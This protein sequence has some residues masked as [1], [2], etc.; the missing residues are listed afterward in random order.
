MSFLSNALGLNTS[1]QHFNPGNIPLQN[2]VSPEQIQ[3]AQQQS[4][5]AL[6]GFQ[7]L[8]Q[9]GINTQVYAQQQQ[10]ANQLMQ[11]AQG[12]GPNPAQAQLNQATGQNVANQAALM[13]SQRGASANPNLVAKQAAQQ[14]SQ[15]QQQA[16]GQSATMGAQQQLAAQQA[17]MGQQSQMAGQNMGIQNAYTQAAQAQL[18]QM[19]GGMQ[20][21]NQNQLQL[22]GIK[23]GMAQSQNQQQGALAGGLLNAAGTVG[24]AM[25]SE[26]G[27]VP[28]QPE[29]PHNDPQNDKVKAML[30]PGELVIPLDAMKSKEAAIEFVNKHFSKK[31]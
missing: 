15:I 5:Q 6:G 22:G 18:Q 29:V 1:Q 13:G 23:A 2:T 16:A 7:P 25:F 9:Q 26:G 21:Q 24:A 30:S 28:G 3:F 12:Q 27:K 17:L 20:A 11:Q 19:M 10:L 4:Q 8:L 31:A 14:G